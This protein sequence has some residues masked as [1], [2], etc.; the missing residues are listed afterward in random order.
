[1]L[2]GLTYKGLRLVRAKKKSQ[3]N[4]LKKKP[5]KTANEY[6]INCHK[7]NCPFYFYAKCEHKIGESEFFDADNWETLQNKKTKNHAHTLVEKDEEKLAQSHSTLVS[8]SKAPCNV[9]SEKFEMMKHRHEMKKSS[10]SSQAAFQTLVQQ[11]ENVS[12]IESIIKSQHQRRII[13]QFNYRQRSALGTEH[14]VD[15]LPTEA[16]FCDKERTIPFYCPIMNAKNQFNDFFMYRGP[17]MD[18]LLRTC[19]TY[20]FDGTFSMP[21]Y[22][23]LSVLVA[24]IDSGDI[25]RSDLVVPVFYS[26]QKSRTTEAYQEMWA[27]FRECVPDGFI[28][29][30]C[31]CDTESAIRASL[32]LEFE[33]CKVR[34]CVW[35]I[36]M[37][38]RSNG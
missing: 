18:E 28:M 33:K 34:L 30:T 9:P 3:K 1:M 5:S 23:Q 13:D 10:S 8:R 26:A 16:R 21:Q 31:Y 25:T 11:D 27:N 12:K 6:R 19:K 32:K 22:D 15:G 7:R 2:D 35:H 29:E 17:K 14:E 38:W 4:S 24:I 36:L 20:S 37:S